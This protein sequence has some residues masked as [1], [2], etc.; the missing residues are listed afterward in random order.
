[1]VSVTPVFGRLRRSPPPSSSSRRPG[2]HP[3]PSGVVVPL[4]GRAD[5]SIPASGSSMAADA[6]GVDPRCRGSSCAPLLQTRSRGR[7][8]PRPGPR[9]GLVV[10]VDARPGGC[11]LSRLE[12][13][14]PAQA[15]VEGLSLLAGDPR[16]FGVVVA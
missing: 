14:I 9:R 1:M 7:F 16:M 2:A 10:P 13:W 5:R 12:R 8:P 11:G 3:R 4:L 6:L 15:A